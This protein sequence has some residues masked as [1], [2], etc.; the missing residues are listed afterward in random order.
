MLSFVSSGTVSIQSVLE[1]FAAMAGG[2]VIPA[3]NP[4]VLVPIPLLAALA[5]SLALSLA[6]YL[7]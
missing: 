7:L 5:L 1:M 4:R 2:A 6:G 3:K